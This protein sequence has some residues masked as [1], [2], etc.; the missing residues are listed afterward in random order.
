[1]RLTDDNNNNYCPRS[2]SHNVDAVNARSMTNLEKTA[3]DCC[4]YCTILFIQVET[5]NDSDD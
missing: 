5:M 4:S 1:M 3:A 2:R